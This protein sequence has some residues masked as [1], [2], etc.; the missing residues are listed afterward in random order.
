VCR[1]RLRERRETCGLVT[2]NQKGAVLEGPRLLPRKMF[3][4]GHKKKGGNPLFTPEGE[5]WYRRLEK[6]GLFNGNPTE[7]G[8]TGSGSGGRRTKKLG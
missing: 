3:E 7:G 4:R 5:K 6:A 8:G 2:E 1:R